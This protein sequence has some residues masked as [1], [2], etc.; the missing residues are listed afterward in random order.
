M[1]IRTKRK[2][3]RLLRMQNELVSKETIRLARRIRRNKEIQ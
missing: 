2:E 1:M 3:S